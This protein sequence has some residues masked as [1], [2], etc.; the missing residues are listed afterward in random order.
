MSSKNSLFGPLVKNGYIDV[1]MKPGM[2]VQVHEEAIRPLCRQ[3]EF[4]T[5][6]TSHWDSQR[7]WDREV[8]AH[9]V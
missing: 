9:G 1:P 5:D 6:P 8:G 7:G 2:G 3:G 4:F